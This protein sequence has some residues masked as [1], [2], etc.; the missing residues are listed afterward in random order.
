MYKNLETFAQAEERQKNVREKY[1]ED[2]ANQL[3]AQTD[4]NNEIKRAKRD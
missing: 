1:F 4:M 2:K 3:I